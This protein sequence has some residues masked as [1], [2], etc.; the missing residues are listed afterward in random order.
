MVCQKMNIAPKPR[1]MAYRIV[2]SETHDVARIQWESEPTD[3]TADELLEGTAFSEGR[4]AR[5]DRVVKWLRH[6]LT[7]NGGRAG[8]KDVLRAGEALGFSKDT[9]KRAK[10]RAGVD[11]AKMGLGGW[12]WTL[13]EE[14]GE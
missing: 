10:A 4:T 1:A 5:V 14:E 7:E 12:E 3:M 11:T 2:T 8:A 6:Y 13:G 9:V